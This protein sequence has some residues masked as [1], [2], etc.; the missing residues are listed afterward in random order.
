MVAG[1]ATPNPVAEVP[2]DE[3]DAFC[4]A[5]TGIADEPLPTRC[6]ATTEVRCPT[7]PGTHVPYRVRL[8]VIGGTHDG[9]DADAGNLSDSDGLYAEIV[10]SNGNI[11]RQRWVVVN[12]GR[13]IRAVVEGA[14]AGGT[15]VKID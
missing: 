13:E 12:R 7:L 10:Q 6:L 3:A 1:T 14:I 11:L 4:Q 15:R 8:N 2:A 9:V 5:S